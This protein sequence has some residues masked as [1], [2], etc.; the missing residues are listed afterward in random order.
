M[1][2]SRRTKK[3]ISSNH[4]QAPKVTKNKV[5]D[6]KSQSNNNLN[7]KN[8]KSQSVESDFIESLLNKGKKKPV[9]NNLNSIQVKK[10]EGR[11]SL[12]NRLDTS[13]HKQ[14][15]SKKDKIMYNFHHA[16]N[17][18]NSDQIIVKMLELNENDIINF[19]SNLEKMIGK[20]LSY[21]IRDEM[22]RD[23]KNN[24]KI[25]GGSTAVCPFCAEN[26]SNCVILLCG[27]MIC[28]KCGKN[29]NR[30]KYPCP[31]CKKPI[32]YIQFISD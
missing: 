4:N 22:S 26:K 32:K 24:Q 16:I 31:K 12:K 20:E 28:H 1:S 9:S 3:N 18:T 7:A 2:D 17:S 19:Y 11:N 29:I 30:C 6:K 21:Q 5:R 15:R 13:K 25:S 23:I 10:I 14:N 27:H 8:T